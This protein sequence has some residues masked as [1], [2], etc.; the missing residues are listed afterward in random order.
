MLFQ[1]LS[2]AVRFRIDGRIEGQSAIR[3]APRGRRGATPDQ[4][5]VTG[6]RCLVLE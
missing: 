2:C 1:G 4:F 5:P 6:A 3:A